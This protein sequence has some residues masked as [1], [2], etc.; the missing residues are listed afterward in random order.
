MQQTK[1]LILAFIFTTLLTMPAIAANPHE[2]YIS[3]PFETGPD[4]TKA[5]KA[6]LDNVEKWAESWNSVAENHPMV[7]NEFNRG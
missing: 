7:I 1:Q 6:T 5:L 2:Q 4:V 3:G